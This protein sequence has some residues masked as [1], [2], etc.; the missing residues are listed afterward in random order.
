MS[1]LLFFVQ[2]P[3]F[4]VVDV[5]NVCFFYLIHTYFTFFDIFFVVV[6]SNTLRWNFISLSFRGAFISFLMYAVD[7]VDFSLNISFAVSYWVS[8]ILIAFSSN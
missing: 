3:K 8:H 7:T 4:C 1:F 2:G 5:L 6:V